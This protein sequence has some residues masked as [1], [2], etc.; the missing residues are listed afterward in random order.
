M[1]IQN[2]FMEDYIFDSKSLIRLFLFFNFARFQDITNKGA[3]KLFK[4]KFFFKTTNR[5]GREM[6]IIF[7]DYIYAVF[8]F[9]KVLK[10]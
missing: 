6:I 2:C 4:I 3:K 5:F 7:Q 10:N 1:R 9:L 8:D